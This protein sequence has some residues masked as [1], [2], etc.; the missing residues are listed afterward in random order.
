[1]TYDEFRA[2]LRKTPR[3]WVLVEQGGKQLLCRNVTPE[4]EGERECPVQAVAIMRFPNE[5][6]IGYIYAGNL[7]G[8]SVE[9]LNR[10]ADAAD[11]MPWISSETRADL[12]ADCGLVNSPEI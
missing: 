1:M 11:N 7:L 12:L 5:R 6:F 3:D 2:E 4:G 8:L 9:N 10:I